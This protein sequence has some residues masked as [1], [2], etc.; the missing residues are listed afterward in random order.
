MY[1]T[2]SLH[3]I[4]WSPARQLL[5]LLALLCIKPAFA[6]MPG[7]GSWLTLQLPVQLNKKWQWHND[8]GYR[9]I[10]MHT[11]GHQYFYRTG[12]RY[13]FNTHWNSA[14]GIALFYTR[15]SYSKQNQAF[16]RE[17]RLWQEVNN[18]QPIAAQTVLQNRLRVE[19]RFFAAT[20]Q[21]SA[22]NAWRL[23]YRMAL[24][25]RFSNKWGLQLSEEYMAQKRSSSKL[26]FNQN[27]V[28]IA[29]LYQ[30]HPHTQLQAGYMWL[31]WPQSQQHIFQFTF[32]QQIV[33]HANNR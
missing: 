28:A 19:Q 12:L 8:A 27:R 21:S 11:A 24:V 10:G 1:L 18:Q 25:H 30:W 32:Y 26:L 3:I 2:Q 15:T 4:S 22:F 5:I 7:N 31:L 23:R 6:Q 17:F 16:G 33:L 13:Q 20:Q 29:G 14:A 9:T